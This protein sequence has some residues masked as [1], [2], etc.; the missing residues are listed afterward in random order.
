[1]AKILLVDDDELVRYVISKVLRKAE[2]EVLE[3]ENGKQALKILINEN[4]DI[5][6]T[7]IIMPEIEGI[8]LI[9]RLKKSHPDLPIIAISGGSRMVDTGYL[10]SA[11][12]LGAFATLEKPFDEQELL[13]LIS[14]KIE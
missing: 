7:D 4:V 9:M 14:S 13:N 6:I 12:S 1:M 3:A 10:S 11:K 5:L 8:E 2:H